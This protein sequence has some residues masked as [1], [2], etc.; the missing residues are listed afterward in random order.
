MTDVSNWCCTTNENARLMSNTFSRQSCRSRDNYQSH[1]TATRAT[2]CSNTA[3]RRQMVS[4]CWSHHNMQYLTADDL[5]QSHTAGWTKCCDVTWR[6]NDVTGTTDH[7]GSRQFISCVSTLI[8][9]L[10]SFGIDAVSQGDHI[11]TDVSTKNSSFV[12]RT[13][14]S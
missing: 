6:N 9:E 7:T 1:D 5:L 10:C 3:W 14:R 8:Y 11:H 13:S 2:R 4:G 12:S